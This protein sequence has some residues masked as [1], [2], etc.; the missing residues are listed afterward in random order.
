ML[1]CEEGERIRTKMGV[2]S[3]ARGARVG[4][5]YHSPLLQFPDE[6]LQFVIDS[7]PNPV[8][9][10]AVSL[11][12]KRFNAIEGS[13]R[14]AVLISNCYA[15]QP[16]MLVSRFPNAKSVTIKGKPRIVDFSLIPH[17]EVWGAYARPWVEVLT[18]FYRHLRH[19]RLKRMT[20]TDGDI[21][22]LVGACGES[23]QRLELEKCS[24]FSTRGLDIIARGCRNLRE[25]NLSEADIRNEGPLYW[26]TTLAN[27][28]KSLQVLDLSLTELEDAEQH[29][30]VKLATRCH[31]LRLCEALRIDHVLPIVEA[32]D[33]TV[34]QL[35]IGY[36]TSIH[37]VLQV[38]FCNIIVYV[39]L[40]CEVQVSENALLTESLVSYFVSSFGYI[41]ALDSHRLYDVITCSGIDFWGD[42]IVYFCWRCGVGEFLG[43]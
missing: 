13:S 38:L 24:G 8:D 29:V 25:L 20:I 6:I 31:T 4:E 12:C 15:I 32:A 5:E 3:R 23:L 21:E 19:L 26:L 37:K 27:T 1:G 34:R 11:V 2:G 9:R 36:V 35:G 39:H 42:T 30:L 10:N 40:G 22:L 7:L 43:Y 14:E 16:W 17:A 41:F 28:A 33:T 18:R